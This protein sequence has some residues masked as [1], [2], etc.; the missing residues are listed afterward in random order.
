MSTP[1][2]VEYEI[3]DIVCNLVRTQLD[4]SEQRVWI[5]NQKMTIS[6]AAGL[7]VDVAF[8]GAKPFGANTRPLATD[9]GLS[10]IQSVNVQETYTINLYSRDESAFLRAWEVIAALT[11]DASE[12]AQEEYSFQF[13][14]I[15]TGF[16]DT[17]F[18]EASAR[19]FRQTIT[20]NAIRLRTKTR[21]ISY[22]DK[23]R[24]AVLYTNQ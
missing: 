2:P 21:V 19:L 12:K 6:D 10:E 20:F 11:G 14:Q 8:T 22:Y 17:S 5:Y 23:F 4:L 13:S 16:V 3:I 7:F 1:A 15:P 24:K 9:E 18:L